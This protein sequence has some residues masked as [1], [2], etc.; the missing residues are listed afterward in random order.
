MKTNRI[1]SVFLVAAIAGSGLAIQ[2]SAMAQTENV[3]G[4]AQVIVTVNANQSK[5]PAALQQSDITVKVKGRPAAVESVTPINDANEPTQLVFMFD[6]SARSYLALQIP[7]LKKFIMALP[8]STE[9]AVAYM[10]N[11]VAVMAQ[12][13]TADHKKAADSLRL[14]NGIPGITGSP[15][16]CLSDLAKHWPSQEKARR[17]VFMVTNG[18][19]PYYRSRDLQDPY[20]AAAIQDSQKANLLVYSIYFRNTFGG[21]STSFSTLMGQSYLQ[22]L[23][24]ETGGQF[25]SMAM[26]SPVSFEPFLK[27]FKQ[28]LQRQYLLTFAASNTGRQT[29]QVQSKVSG[30]K[31]TAPKAIYVEKNS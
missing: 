24:N 7:D 20:L 23:A 4:Q 22:R 21:G 17:V 9:V 13:M 31:L 19:D 5:S 25:Y 2:S 18:E 10:N 16:F 8:P 3:A 28:S 27:Q 14:T 26:S 29:V 1:A 11:G 15:Y 30:L 6:E 12:K